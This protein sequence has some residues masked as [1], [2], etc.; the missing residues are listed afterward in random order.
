MVNYPNNPT[1]GQRFTL[2]SGVIMECAVA[3][4]TPIWQ[5]LPAVSAVPPASATSTGQTG[6]ITWDSDYI[7]MCIATN[8]WKRVEISTW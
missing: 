3:G 7:Y 4:V 1:V 8:T 5:A 2:P 6:Q